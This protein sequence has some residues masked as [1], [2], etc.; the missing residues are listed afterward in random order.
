MT[1]EE[2]IEFIRTQPQYSSL[3]RDAYFDPNLGVNV[4]RFRNGDE[5]K[6]S[7]RIIQVWNPGK[8]RL[9][10]IGSGNGISSVAFAL[11]GY[12][13]DAVEP[14]PSDT[15]GAGAIR[16]LAKAY[17]LGARLVVHEDFAEDI[18]FDSG[19]FDVVYARQSMHHANDLQK[20]ISESA[21]VL[22]P[23]GILLTVR[24]HVIFDEEDKAHF[25][26]THPLHK[27]YG[28]E[29]AFTREEYESAMCNAGLEVQ[30]V[31]AYYDSVINYFPTTAEDIEKT[32]ND[33]KAFV[34][35]LTAKKLGPLQHIS[36]VSSIY[37]RYL[38]RQLGPLKDERQ[39]PGR[40]Y[41]I[42]ATKPKLL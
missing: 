31:M 22:K 27:Y 24:D 40:M 36:W 35:E 33:R 9:L 6:E 18:G 3:V 23:G 32:A 30:E 20:F 25:L 5:F 26:A 13:V 37:H 21:R 8:G 10:D 19:T 4:E 16:K 38:N 34:A 15:I 14:D 1:W 42:I 41:S 17:D 28:G 39:I 12:Q 7:Y 11:N 2:T 29:N